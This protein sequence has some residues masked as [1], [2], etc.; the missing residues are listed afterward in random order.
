MSQLIL[1]ISFQMTISQLLH[2]YILFEFLKA[3]SMA[4]PS[5]IQLTAIFDFYFLVLD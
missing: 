5:Q 4:S 3:G 1:F 2:A